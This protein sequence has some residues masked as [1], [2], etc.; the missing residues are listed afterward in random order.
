MAVDGMRRFGLTA[1]IT[2]LFAIFGLAAAA[3]L[4][5]AVSGLDSVHDIDREAFAGQQLANKAALLSSRVAQASLLSRF[6]DTSEPAAVQ[7]SYRRFL[8]NRLRETF[9]LEGTPVRLRLR[10]RD[11]PAYSGR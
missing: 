6:D 4:A 11:E 2:V 3:G 7:T 8:E 1:K 5:G 9:D 10:A